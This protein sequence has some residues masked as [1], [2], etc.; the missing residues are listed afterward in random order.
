MTRISLMIALFA[1]SHALGENNDT[2]DPLEA[3][4]PQLEWSAPA[5]DEAMMKQLASEASAMNE[6]MAGDLAQRV[7][8]RMVDILHAS[9]PTDSPLSDPDKERLVIK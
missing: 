4:L 9:S 6:K 5:L 2:V 1:T 3:Q 8:K 7:Q